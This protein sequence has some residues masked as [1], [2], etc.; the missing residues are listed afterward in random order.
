MIFKNL[1]RHIA[2]SERP[3]LKKLFGVQHNAQASANNRRA[4]RFEGRDRFYKVH[5]PVGYDKNKPAAVVLNF[6][7]GG[8]SPDDQEIQ[9]G[10]DMVSDRHGFIVVYPGGTGEE[11]DRKL[12]FN[13][14]NVH[15]YAAAHNVNDVGF[16]EYLI[17]EV[18]RRFAVDRTRIF[19]TGFSIGA[20]F[21][22]LLA[23]RLPHLIAAIGPVSG[24]LALPLSEYQPSRCVP[25][26]HF[27]GTL[28]SINPYRG[29]VAG[30]PLMQ[31]LHETTVYN[32]S[33]QDMIRHCVDFYECRKDSCRRT[34]KGQALCEAY[35]PGKENAE[36]ILWTL[37][38][39]G[40]T[41]PGG[42]RT[43]PQFVV[44]DVNHDICASELIWE[45]FKAHPL[46]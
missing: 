13:A 7:G 1:P 2:I 31:R 10:M 26:I 36:V 41:W 43:L 42:T 14:G 23:A 16:I 21:C 12:F 8:G 37:Q 32:H 24:T 3:L 4:L 11:D 17:E 5:L 29:G 22:Y 18:G 39:A 20:K 46:P 38:G 35:G 40:H 19:A 28:D 25:I 30:S 15:G 45:F 44:G 6:H 34:Q 33:V 9:S 27:H